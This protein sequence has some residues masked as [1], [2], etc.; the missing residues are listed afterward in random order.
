MA[1]ANKKGSGSAT[2]T[3]RNK[4]KPVP[5]QKAIISP[6]VPALAAQRPALGDVTVAVNNTDSIEELR[7]RSTYL[8]PMTSV[9]YLM[10]TFYSTASESTGRE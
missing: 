1:P 10:R 7:G 6:P 5:I 4:I 8:Q 3:T 2:N 9:A